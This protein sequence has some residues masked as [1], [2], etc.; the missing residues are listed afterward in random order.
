MTPVPLLKL[1][2][3]QDQQE[4]ILG[5]LGDMADEDATEHL[6]GL[7]RA[8]EEVV[9]SRKIFID[10]YPFWDWASVLE[11]SI[12]GQ[13][14]SSTSYHLVTDEVEDRQLVRQFVNEFLAGSLGNVRLTLTR[15]HA[16]LTLL[17]RDDS[18]LT[19]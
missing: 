16:V 7:Q 4:A 2:F 1:A 17:P 15:P 8:V 10:R 13:R 6:N 14:G 11:V 3:T 19:Y 9:R 12:Q 18:V 5:Y